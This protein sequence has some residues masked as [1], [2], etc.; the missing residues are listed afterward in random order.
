[1]KIIENNFLTFKQVTDP[2]ATCQTICNNI[3]ND[4]NAPENL[5][6]VDLPLAFLLNNKGVPGTQKILNELEKK[7]PNVQ[8]K[9]VCQHILVNKLNF[10]NNKV[11]TP[12]TLYTDNNIVIP[13]YNPTINEKDYIPLDKRIY[14]LSFVGCFLTHPLRRA[15][16]SFNNNKDIIIRETGGWHF[17]KKIDDQLKYS[18]KY[19]EILC[20]T[21]F[22]LCPPGTGVST[23]RLYESMAAGSIPVLFNNVKVPKIVEKYV[24][25]VQ[26]INDILKIDIKEDTI[27]KAEELKYIYWSYLSNNNMH[28]IL[29]NE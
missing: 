5:N 18:A 24:I 25:R 27:Q 19:K 10:F 21:K 26:N 9:Y 28:R 7:Y 15:V 4:K 13:H 12:H 1:M 2:V 17:S 11:Y 23:I 6:Y 20:N 22:S 16:A 3:L 29:Y 8:K 14:K